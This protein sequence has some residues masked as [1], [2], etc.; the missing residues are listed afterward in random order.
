[1]L[2]LTKTVEEWWA[3]KTAAAATMAVKV[4]VKTSRQEPVSKAS[5]TT[6]TYV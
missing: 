4:T 3:H 2:W 1:M 6:A 5:E